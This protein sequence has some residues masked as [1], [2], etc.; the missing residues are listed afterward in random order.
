MLLPSSVLITHN[1]RLQVAAAKIQQALPE[2]KRDGNT[3]LT[4]VNAD[5]LYDESST[6]RAGGLLT[7]M[8]FVPKL[9]E[10]LNEKPEDVVK[11]FEDFRSYCKSQHLDKDIGSNG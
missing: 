6:G 10:K 5:L 1:G 4:S 2:M 3:V 9:I 11:A 8:E 7:Q